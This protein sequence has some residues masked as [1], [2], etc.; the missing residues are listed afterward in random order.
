[1][2][3]QSEPVTLEAEPNDHPAQTTAVAMPATVVGRLEKNEDVDGF[4]VALESGQ[5][6]VASCLAHRVL[7]SPMDAV[8]QLCDADGNVLAQS[9]DERGIDPQIVYNA[10]ERRELIVRL[11]AFPETPT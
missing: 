11:F 1:L 6:L 3:V 5:T 2:V 4:R 8:L 9:D 7:G 10:A